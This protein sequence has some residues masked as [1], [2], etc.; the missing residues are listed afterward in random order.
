M[1]SRIRIAVLLALC[2]CASVQA[3]PEY[4]P[5]EIVHEQVLVIQGQRVR[6]LQHEGGALCIVCANAVHAQ[7]RM[8]LIHGQRVAVHRPGS[9]CDAVF[10][11]D[12][13]KF[14]AALQPRGAFLG[15]EPAQNVSLGW[16]FAGIYVLIGLVFAGL[17]G[18][19]ALERGHPQMAWFLG[20]LFFNV[21][22][23]A[24]LRMKAPRPV[25]APAGV[26]AGLGKIAATYD[27]VD[28]ACGAENH[29]AAQQCSTCG[30][31]LQP[32]VI[33]EVARLRQ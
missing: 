33:S 10:R 29:P 22:A 13:G 24:T 31:A 1:G 12:A 30:R 11:E 20:G 26:P 14:L 15:G 21:I 17:C 23:Y 9:P 5:P 2:P 32:Q 8:Y 6:V 28:C 16:F 25:T 7:D 19:L 4:M 27:P 18:Q 3:Q